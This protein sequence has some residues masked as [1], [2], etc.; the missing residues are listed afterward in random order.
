MTSDKGIVVGG[1]ALDH[2]P[3]G[4]CGAR[5]QALGP[6]LIHHC[7]EPVIESEDVSGLIGRCVWEKNDCKEG[8]QILGGFIF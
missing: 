3:G 4:G 5:C 1:G 6:P 2:R 8:K 7:S